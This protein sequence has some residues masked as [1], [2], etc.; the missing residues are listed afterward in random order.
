MSGTHHPQEVERMARETESGSINAEHLTSHLKG[1]VK[2]ALSAE[3][4]VLY[5][6]SGRP[7]TSD[8]DL[9]SNAD[10]QWRRI[11]DELID[12]VI[13]ALATELA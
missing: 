8:S 12:T 2:Q 5:D 9:W 11:A 10:N 13:D 6:P 3:Q 4:V 7:I 1:A